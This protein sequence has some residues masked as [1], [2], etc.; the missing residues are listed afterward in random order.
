[1]TKGRLKSILATSCLN[2]AG[3]KQL[4]SYTR[5]VID[6]ANDLA[7]LSQYTTLNMIGSLKEI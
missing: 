3:S 7:N 4:I 5:V 6:S 2:I 1:M